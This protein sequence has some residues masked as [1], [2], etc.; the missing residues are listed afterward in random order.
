MGQEKTR[1]ISTPEAT[2]GIAEADLETII[3]ITSVGQ[4]ETP[5]REAVDDQD[6]AAITNALE[7]TEERR[8]QKTEE[9]REGIMIE[10]GIG[11]T[12]E[13]IVVDME[14]ISVDA[15]EVI[16]EDD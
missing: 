7:M 10:R 11:M 15:L 4:N 9:K 5:S 1:K 12:E 2:Q 16:K 3:E 13:T 14:M 8:S 6:L